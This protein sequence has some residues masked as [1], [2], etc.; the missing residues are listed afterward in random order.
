MAKI[1]GINHVAFVVKDLDESI[2]SAVEVLGGKEIFKFESLKQKYIGV[3]I[4]FGDSFIS[5]LYATDESSFVAQHIEKW[6]AGPQHMGLTIDNLEEYVGELEAKGIRVDKS[7]MKD[8]K[9]K[10]ALVG[11]RTGFGL[12]LQLMQWE[13]GALDVTPEGIERVKQKY[14]ETPD[15]RIIE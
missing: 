9:F 13:E 8:E 11:P 15:L 3:M 10:E 2:K 1:L 4:Q 6:G 5:L 7:D 12:V 14:R